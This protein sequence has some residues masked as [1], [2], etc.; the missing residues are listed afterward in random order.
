[1]PTNSKTTAQ[2]SPSA[3]LVSKT[4]GNFRSKNDKYPF[5]FGGKSFYFKCF[6]TSSIVSTGAASC[7]SCLVTHPL[8][9]TKVRMQTT[10]STNE[11]GSLGTAIMIIR[12]EGILGIYNGISASILRQATYSTMRFGIYDKLRTHLTKNG[13]PLSFAAKIFCA[14]AAGCVGGAFGSPADLVMVRMQNDAKLPSELR[15]NYKNAFEGLFRIYREEGMMGLTRGI[16]PNVNRAIL[17][18]S[19]QLA[20]YEQFK[21]LLLETEYFQDN[22]ITHF[23]SSLM[24]GLVATTI[25]SPVDVIKT[26]VMNS[27]SKQKQNIMTM[28]KTIIV[29]EGPFALFKGWVPAFVRLGPHTIVTFLALEQIKGFYNKRI[30]L[31]MKATV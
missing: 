16:G 17:M 21:Q 9:T 12:K 14:S 11:L 1:M 22:I 26:R 18:N 27:G 10:I 3:I 2:V 24:A 13:E 31:R 29:R 23:T 7:F 4:D 25:C 8:D 19:A 28:L 20:S 30:E 5:W 15:R 6:E